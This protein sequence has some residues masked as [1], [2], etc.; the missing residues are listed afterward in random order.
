MLSSES[1][2]P[3]TGPVAL[4]SEPVC[5]AD[6][7]QALPCPRLSLPPLTR[8]PRL[9]P[10]SLCPRL[11]PLS[12]YRVCGPRSASLYELPA[13]EFLLS[14]DFAPASIDALAR[15]HDRV[16]LPRLCEEA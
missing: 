3:Y 8:C 15:A 16:R 13:S 11:P 2:R 10:R 1:E 5:P 9:P 4:R 14:S 12:L 6:L 7:F